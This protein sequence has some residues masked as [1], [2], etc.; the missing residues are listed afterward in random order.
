MQRTLSTGLA[1]AAALVLTLPSIGQAAPRRKHNHTPDAVQTPAVDDTDGGTW[2]VGVGYLPSPVG[3][4][5]ALSGTYRIMP[6]L[7]IDGLLLGGVSS[8]PLGGTN[9]S[10]APVNDGT[11]SFGIGAQA[12]YSLLHPTSFLDFQ[13]VGRLSFVTGTDSHEVL[14]TTVN[15][16]AS[17]FGMFVG[18]GFEGFIPAW[19]V[20]SIEVNS[21]VNIALSGATDGPY[22]AGGSGVWLGASNANAFVPLNLAVHYYF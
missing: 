13:L 2:G 19:R 9:A 14:G 3:A 16:S 12:R 10:G 20:V 1:L 17:E 6:D 15:S 18:A 21:G 4:L 8:V 5:N 11:G 7:K 22:S